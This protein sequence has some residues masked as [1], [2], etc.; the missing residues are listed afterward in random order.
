MSLIASD[1]HAHRRSSWSLAPAA[2][3]L[4][5]RISGEDLDRLIRVNPGKVLSGE[6]PATVKPSGRRRSWRNRMGIKL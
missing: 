5:E 2:A 6:R 3:T 4:R 1:A